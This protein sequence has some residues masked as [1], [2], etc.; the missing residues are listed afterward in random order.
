MRQLTGLL[1]TAHPLQAVATATGLTAAAALSGRDRALSLVVVFG[2]V[3]LG[4]AIQGW[5]NDLTDQR[6]DAARQ[7]SGK[8]IATGGVDRGN[9]WF[10]LIVATLAVIPLA[11][12]NGRVAGGCYLAAVLVGC[13]ANRFLRGSVLSFLPWAVQFALYAF[14]V[15]E[16][17]WA[18]VGSGNAPRPVV[19]VLLA[20][21][22]VGVH[23]LLASRGLVADHEDGLRSL[24]LRVALRIG[25]N[26]LLIVGV[27]FTV[28]AVVALLI[29]A[30]GAGWHG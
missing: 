16:G 15:T 29:V 3:L 9:A 22:G 4:Q 24:P 25:A 26:R 13:V 2:T 27:V 7:A 28:A 10:A 17:G 20:L 18:G 1:R 11:V 19:V 5:H 14:F 30:Q 12:A 8:P 21:V 23:L 6:R